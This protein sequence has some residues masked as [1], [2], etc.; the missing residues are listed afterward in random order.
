MFSKIYDA[1]FHQAPVNSILSFEADGDGNIDLL[2]GGNEY[3]AEPV[4]G[5]YDASYGLVLKGNWKGNFIPLD[6]R[7]TG[8]ILDGDVKHLKTLNPGNK[9][10]LIIAAI[11]DEKIKCFYCKTPLIGQL[12]YVAYF[13][14]TNYKTLN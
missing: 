9:Q 11:N 4:T 14:Y 8:F 13:Y 2:L 7:E 12:Y 5:R 6:Y 10:K 1:Y 3:Q